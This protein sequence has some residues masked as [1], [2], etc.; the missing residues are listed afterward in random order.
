MGRHVRPCRPCS[1]LWRC[2]Q[3]WTPAV[4]PCP[5]TRTHNSG[6]WPGLHVSAC[7]PTSIPPSTPRPPAASSTSSSEPAPWQCC[8]SFFFRPSEA[9]HHAGARHGLP[10]PPA[11]RD[12]KRG[13][14]NFVRVRVCVRWAPQRPTNPCRCRH[15][16]PPHRWVQQAHGGLQACRCKHR[17]RHRHHRRRPTSTGSRSRTWH[18]LPT[19]G[20]TKPGPPPHPLPLHVCLVSPPPPPLPSP[21]EVNHAHTCAPCRAPHP[22]PQKPLPAPF[23]PHCRRLSALASTQNHRSKTMDH[24]WFAVAHTR[25][26]GARPSGAASLPPYGP[27]R[28]PPT[29]SLGYDI[30]D[31][32]PVPDAS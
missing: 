25:N 12:L 16:A 18:P 11:M 3:R 4:Q 32:G 2:G 20:S 5:H 27:A 31:V 17:R 13:S 21:L 10:L 15:E 8:L 19:S 23:P 24:R 28:S 14:C 1:P 29:P 6:P 22:A 7:E 26:P 30:H 9:A